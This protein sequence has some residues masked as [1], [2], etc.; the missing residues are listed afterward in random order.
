MPDLPLFEYSTALS[1]MDGHSGKGHRK[2]IGTL[3]S[4]YCSTWLLFDL[5]YSKPAFINKEKKR[6]Q[7]SY[8][9]W[10]ICEWKEGVLE[11]SVLSDVALDTICNIDSMQCAVTGELTIFGELCS[12]I[13]LLSIQYRE[14]YK[15]Y[16]AGRQISTWKGS[17]LSF[18]RSYATTSQSS[19][20][21]LILGFTHLQVK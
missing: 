14:L 13:L 2:Q 7:R 19:T 12:N 10:R 16:R 9:A 1:T 4:W 20:Y 8:R 6:H 5:L 18:S 15:F 21:V 3:V 11:R 17:T